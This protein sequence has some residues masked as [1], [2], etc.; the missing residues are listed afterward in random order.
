MPPLLVRLAALL[1]VCV[2][3]VAAGAP[4][5]AV[6]PVLPR[7]GVLGV[8][9]GD[10]KGGGAAVLTVLPGSAGGAAGLQRGDVIASVDG[11]PVA[12]NREF[13]AKL[14]RPA[15]EPVALG[16]VR[17]GSPS[18]VRAVLSPAAD[19]SDPLVDTRYDALT[20]EGTLRRTL[21]TVPHGSTGKHPAL[22]FVGGI[23]CYSV[24]VA[25]NPQDPYL[26]LSHDLS[27]RGFVTLRLEKSGLGDSQGPPCATVD[28]VTEAASYTAAY[29]ALARDPAVDPKRI[30]V[31]GHSI[32]TVIAPRLALARATAGIIAA[33]GVGRGWIEYELINTRRQLALTGANPAEVDDAMLGKVRCIDRLLLQ[34]EDEKTIERDEPDCAEHN[35]Y[36]APAAYFR[37]LAALDIA[38]PWMKLNLPVLAIYGSADFITDEADHRRIVDVVNGIHPGAAQLAVI[39]GMDHY[40]TPAGSQQASFQ[41]V[42]KTH[43]PA[44]YDERFSAAVTQWLC[45]REHCA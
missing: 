21:V 5:T 37:Q 30:Y 11:T 14:R 36:P 23:G 40:L 15:G 18:T 25:T 33:E 9:T 35:V 13:L 45:A 28:Y 24:D 1:T 34:K 27:R 22:L 26:R 6:G 10:A 12:N 32:G 43:A 38:E 19:E 8:A 4:A 29:D 3:L 2:G 17:A 41:R 20:F 42:T 7:H 44:P 16:I 39:D 31:F